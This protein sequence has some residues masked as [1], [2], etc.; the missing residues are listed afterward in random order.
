MIIRRNLTTVVKFPAQIQ[1]HFTLDNNVFTAKNISIYKQKNAKHVK[2]KTTMIQKL[3]FAKCNKKPL[4]ILTLLNLL[5]LF[6]TIRL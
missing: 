5:L 4:P 6:P 2:V 1:L 3:I